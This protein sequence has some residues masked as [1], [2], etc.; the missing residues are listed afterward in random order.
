MDKKELTVVDEQ[1]VEHLLH[2]LFTCDNEERKAS[3]VFLYENNPD[4]VMVMRYDE[5]TNGLME[6]EDEDEYQE[7][8]E[9]FNSCQEDPTFQTIK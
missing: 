8:E 6:I 9:I 4:E 5:A 2:V 3:Y 1:G 7:L